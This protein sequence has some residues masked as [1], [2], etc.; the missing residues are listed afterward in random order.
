MPITARHTDRPTLDNRHLVEIDVARLLKTKAL[1]AAASGAGKSWAVRRIVEQ[2][3]LHVQ[4]FVT[5]PE[6]E[7]HTL[8]ERY[9]F[10]LVGPGGEIAADVAR[11]GEVTLKLLEVGASAIFDLS[12]LG[13]HKDAYIAAS[14]TALVH[15]PR[16]L[17]RSLLVVLDEAQR[18]A[19]EAGRGDAA[20][21][22]AVI[23]Y[24]T[25]G[26]KRGFGFLVATQRIAELH[27][28]VAA[29][30]HNKLIGRTDLGN[31]IKR[32]AATLGMSIKEAHHVLQHLPDGTFY[33]TGSA[34]Q[35][36][37]VE[38]GA[39]PGGVFTVAIGAVATTH[40]DPGAPA[41]PT[42]PAPDVVRKMVA[43][44]AALPAPEEADVDKLRVRVREL[45]AEVSAKQR[46][47]EDLH[48][49]VG[50]NG[51]I[52]TKVD[53]LVKTVEAQ[54]D[55]LT[56][57]RELI[58][59]LRER[60]RRDADNLR[61]VANCLGTIHEQVNA[62]L[63]MPKINLDD[64][65]RHRVEIV[66]DGNGA[67]PD[68]P[69]RPVVIPVKENPDAKADFSNMMLV[70]GGDSLKLVPKPPPRP[71]APGADLSTCERT[72]LAVL[73]TDP[74]R[75]L[76]KQQILIYANYASN[77]STS[78]AFG[79]F[80]REGWMVAVSRDTFQITSGGLLAL[81]T[82]TPHLTGDKLRAAIRSKFDT[83]ERKLFDVICAHYPRAVAKGQILAQAGYASNGSTSSAFGMFIARGFATSPATAQLRAAEE[84]FR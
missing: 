38:G 33:G 81:G 44:L 66:N 71:V 64:P 62:A 70:P 21:T 56:A 52:W 22:E 25:L 58:E 27:N 61:N 19:P 18:F 32:A 57:A 49:Q 40:P 74:N 23:S 24:A 41:P 72:M 11:A 59:Q 67:T 20:S 4:Q 69:R 43:E 68:L 5:D 29:E 78:T 30:L 84:L 60:R 42:T 65:P 34:W 1:V 16:K 82:F 39:Q 77:G 51:D 63:D 53:E 37:D 46:G 55:T 50:G 47:Y 12:E 36:V 45:E 13:E 6:G 75:A 7:Y 48:E 79:R 73:G 2:T 9:P 83:C 28:S 15:A 35:P 14:L 17:W 76:T 3:A 80:M 26:R 31:D 8:R 54:R 10:V